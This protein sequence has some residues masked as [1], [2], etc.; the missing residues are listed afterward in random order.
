MRLRAEEEARQAAEQARLAME[1]AKEAAEQA[2]RARLELEQLVALTQQQGQSPLMTSKTDLE[3]TPEIKTEPSPESPKTYT[4]S[5][6]MVKAHMPGLIIR[7]N[8]KEGDA[9]KTGQV[10]GL[11]EA[12]KMDNPI[13]APQDGTVTAVRVAPGDSVQSGQTLFEVG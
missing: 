6:G 7:V 12:M 5:I 8:V 4:N 1:Q 13:P 11:L 3:P 2:H 9:V 10:L